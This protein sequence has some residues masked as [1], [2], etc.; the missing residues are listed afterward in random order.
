MLKDL[1]KS[2]A[3][4]RQSAND[5]RDDKSV[6]GKGGCVNRNDLQTANLLTAGVAASTEMV[7]RQQIC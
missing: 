4:R 3:G 6:D 2:G 7:S 5:H 1:L